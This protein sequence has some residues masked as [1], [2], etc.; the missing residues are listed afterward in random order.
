[1]NRS[2][3][4]AL[5]LAAC[6]SDPPATTDVPVTTDVPA[7]DP[8]CEAIAERCHELDTGPGVP[9]DCHQFSEGGNVAMCIARMAECFA[10]CPERTD[11]GATDAASDAGDGGDAA[12]RDPVCTL[13]GS[14]CHPYDDE[15]GG[16]GHQCHELG[17]AG[18]ATMCAAR[19]AECLAACPV[20]DAGDAATANDAA[21][22]ASM[23]ASHH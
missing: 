23:D 7:K 8:R 19:Q 1:M 13:I 12:A 20:V 4:F 9:H 11:G 15:D 17:H 3:I 14:R 22:D 18:T 5:V 16:V 6:S 21:N 10:A 2:L